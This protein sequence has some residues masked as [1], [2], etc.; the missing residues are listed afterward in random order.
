MHS[1]DTKV[2]D[3]RH[4]SLDWFLKNNVYCVHRTLDKDNWTLN[5]CAQGSQSVHNRLLTQGLTYPY[6]IPCEGYVN[7][8][9]IMESGQQN[10]VLQVESFRNRYIHEVKFTFL[11]IRQR[12]MN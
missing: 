3:L 12:K 4:N 5:S 8:P 6:R 7:N 1:F 11:Y 10:N 2:C 9:T